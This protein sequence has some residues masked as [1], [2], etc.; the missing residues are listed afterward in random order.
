MYSVMEFMIHLKMAAQ[1]CLYSLVAGG[2]IKLKMYC[3]PQKKV[4][5]RFP[6]IEDE[7]ERQSKKLSRLLVANSRACIQLRWAIIWNTCN[8]I[9]FLQSSQPTRE[10]EFEGAE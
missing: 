7:S 1:N 2:Q 9:F 4:A 3:K 5:I 6:V 10:G 8:P